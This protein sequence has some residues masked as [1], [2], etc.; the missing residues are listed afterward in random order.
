LANQ[1]QPTKDHTR[2]LPDMLNILEFSP[3]F[4]GRGDLDITESL[5]DALQEIPIG[6]Q[7]AGRSQNAVTI[8]FPP[9]QG[10]AAYVI[11]KPIAIPGNK[12]V[13]LAAGSP[14][15]ARIELRPRAGSGDQSIESGQSPALRSLGGRRAHVIENLI[16]RGAGVTIGQRN[17]AVGGM[18]EFRSCVF[19]DIKDPAATGNPNL[20]KWAIST[21]GPR[22]VGVRVLNCQFAETD[23]GI[24]VLH[25]ACDNWIIG[26][27]STFVRM[28]GVGVDIRSSGVT[29]RDARFEDKLRGG[30]LSPYIRIKGI[31]GKDTFAGGLSEITGCRFGG[32]V[33]KESDE[34]GSEEPDENGS[35]GSEDGRE[36]NGKLLDGPPR[37]AIEL[38]PNNPAAKP[39]VGVLITRNRFLGRTKPEGKEFED[40][41]GGPTETSAVHA[42]SLQAPVRHT[43]VAENHFHRYFSALIEE[44]SRNLIKD[45]AGHLKSHSN[46]FV[47]NA[48]ERQA[49]RPETDNREFQ[50][51]FSDSGKSWQSWP[52]G[53]DEHL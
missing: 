25:N 24:G 7:F 47:G 6:H 16:F 28:Q 4:L 3:V 38:G 15:G 9:L 34:A 51:V 31:S 44:T 30:V 53:Q 27:N 29:V 21:E 11:T 41:V 10:E 5:E 32:E 12:N 20:L 22:V 1:K 46:L 33:G 13:R 14:Y 36:R 48:V 45:S 37:H 8:V 2:H 49:I 43:V 52:P 18:T 19:A 42:I 40:E 23:R 35:S 26:D 17:K 39:I 50:G